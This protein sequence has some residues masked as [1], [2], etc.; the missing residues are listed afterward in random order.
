MKRKHKIN[1]LLAVSCCGKHI[2]DNIF[3]IFMLHNLKTSVK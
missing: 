2:Y 3:A 1:E